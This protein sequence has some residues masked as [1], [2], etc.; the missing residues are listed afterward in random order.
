MDDKI[1]QGRDPEWRL[2]FEDRLDDA[3]QARVRRAVKNGASVSDPDEAA[4]AVGLA[5][6]EERTVLRL[7][8]ILLPIQVA[9]AVVWV[10]FFVAGGLPTIFGWFWVAV[11][12][13]VM[14]VVPFM[15]RRRRH[16]ARQAVEANQ[17]VARRSP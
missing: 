11:L 14:V 2:A 15:L 16:V 10:F 9:I 12:L 4:I 1:Q 8:L 3:A 13:V 17:Q 7:G 6:R 5:R